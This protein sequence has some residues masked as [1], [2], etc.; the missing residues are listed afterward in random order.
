LGVLQLPEG[1]W[2]F[3]P[4]CAFNEIVGPNSITEHPNGGCSVTRRPNQIQLPENACAK[5]TCRDA[6]SLSLL[7]RAG[8]AGCGS[9]LSSIE[10]CH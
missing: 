7:R 8:G 5:I 9:M 2:S 3:T 1:A 10:G 6:S 4:E